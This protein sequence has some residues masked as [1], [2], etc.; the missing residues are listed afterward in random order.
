MT[1]YIKKQQ[2]KTPTFVSVLRGDN[3]QFRSNGASSHQHHRGYYWIQTC[4]CLWNN[5]PYI[6][7]TININTYKTNRTNKTNRLLFFFQESFNSHPASICSIM[8]THTVCNFYPGIFVNVSVRNHPP[9]SA[10]LYLVYV[11]LCKC[12]LLFYLLQNIFLLRLS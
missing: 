2:N 7:S 10:A 1:K 11:M 12:Y 3:Y 4:V 6:C 9:H 5:A 8:L